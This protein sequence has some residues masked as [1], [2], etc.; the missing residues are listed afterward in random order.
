MPQSPLGKLA[1]LAGGAYRRLLEK[2]QVRLASNT[3]GL[4]LLAILGVICGVFSGGII[5][6]FRLLIESNITTLL[7]ADEPEGFESLSGLTRFLLCLG[8]GLIVGLILHLLNA[9][10]RNVGVVHVLERLDYHQGYLPVKN[11]IVQFITASIALISG[12]SVGKEGP[13]VHLGAAGGSSL[14]RLL[15]I[16]NNGVRILTASGVAAAI[17]AAFDTPLA[18]VIFAMEV[19]IME[20][21]VIGFAPVILASVSAATLARITLGD[22]AHFIVPNLTI[23]SV[24]ELPIIAVMGALIGVLAAFFIQTTMLTTTLSK[25][26][27]IWV[28]TTA[29]GAITGLIALQIPE[30]MGLGYDTID[31]LL[32]VTP[33]ITPEIGIG[34]GFVV[35]LML[36]KTLATASAIGLGVP[37]GLI[38]PTI[39]IGAAAGAVAGM[40]VAKLWPDYIQHGNIGLYVVLG[41]AAMMAATLQAP[42]AAL[43]YLLELTSDQSI[44]LPGMVVVITAYLITNTVFGKSSIY[45]HLM[46]AKGLDHRNS[47]LAVALRRVG[48]ASIMDRDIQQ[49]N[50]YISHAQARKLLAEKA[51]V[52]LL[53]DEE[54]NQRTSLLPTT[55]L[56]H[57]LSQTKEP[58]NQAKADANTGDD[59]RELDLLKIPA[60]RL[61]TAPI[62]II[63]TLQEAQEKMDSEHCDV[64]YITGAH[65]E[66]KKRIYGIITRNHIERSYRV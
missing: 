28:R 57:Y 3:E 64:L 60:K 19:V 2:Q 52:L 50:R 44:I 27:A 53:V 51:T 31:T 45:R 21:T 25:N 17:S 48:V 4:L 20:Y 56:A 46:L 30:I 6:L 1:T 26:R 58:L 59:E 63:A 13:S 5:I 61:N 35:I 15:S 39:F 47:P 24:S 8:G 66:F 29:A 12:Q 40:I 33:E 16:P 14:G 22:G 65:G 49:Q 10:S 55:D 42:L 41:M 11:A 38:G 32:A 54:N 37:A 36:A 23:S 34:L 62:T 9:K 7:P 18:G 43:V